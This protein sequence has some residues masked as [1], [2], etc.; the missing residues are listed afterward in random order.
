M[1]WANDNEHWSCVTF[2]RNFGPHIVEASIADIDF[3]ETPD[4]DFVLAPRYSNG[5]KNI[6]YAF[7]LKKF[8]GGAESTNSSE[9]ADYINKKASHYSNPDLSMIV[10]PV[11]KV[12]TNEK[13]GFDI[14]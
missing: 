4:V 10:L 6:G 12:D 7:Q 5:S 1:V 11:N 3:N 9:V 8:V 13:K 14:S 2:A